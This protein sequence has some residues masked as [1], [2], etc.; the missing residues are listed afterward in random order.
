[1]GR[2]ED[3]D[4]YWG[5]GVVKEAYVEEFLKLGWAGYYIVLV[6]TYLSK[7]YGYNP[8][9]AYDGGL[10]LDK[11]SY[12]L[13]PEVREVCE[14]FNYK[15][16]PRTKYRSF[17]GSCNNLRNPY[18]GAAMTRT[19]RLVVPD[20]HDGV[21]GIRRSRDGTPLPPARYLR[22]HLL[23]DK[24]AQE[25]AVNTLSLYYGQ[26]VVHDASH[27]PF[28]QAH[29]GAFLDCCAGYKGGE[30][31]VSPKCYTVPLPKDDTFYSKQRVD[32]LNQART[33]LAP[34][35]RCAAGYG[36]QV[37]RQSA[38][39][40]LSLA[41]GT[42]KNESD[43][44]RTKEDGLLKMSK[45]GDQYLLPFDKDAEC[46]NTTDPGFCMTS[47]DLRSTIHPGITLLQ[48]LIN[49]NHNYC[50]KKIYKLNPHWNDEK[51]FQE[52]R[53][54][55]IA[56]FQHIT[57]SEYLP[58]ILGWKFMFD[59]GLLPTT[60]G[61]SYDYDETVN[62][63]VYAEFTGAAFRCHSSVYGK[64]FLMD[65]NYNVEKV[66]D[67]HNHY[68]DPTI[69]KT[70]SNFDSL[71]RG[72]LTSP[73]RKL[74]KYYDPSIGELLL[75]DQRHFGLDIA[76]F[77]INRGREYGIRSYNDYR[78]LCGLPR[79]RTWQDFYDWIS[80]ENVA[81]LQKSYR[82]PDDVDVYTAGLLERHQ[83]DS[84]LGPTWWCIAG[85]Q[86]KNWKTG[87]R[88]FYDLGGQPHSFTLPQ[89]D[90]I[91]RMS[92]AAII[93]TL[94]NVKHVPAF[95]FHTISNG[96]PLVACSDIE[97]IPRLQFGPWKENPYY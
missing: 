68:N 38:V 55:N 88:F 51:I 65:E 64:I 78:E 8:A 92:M 31:Q 72:Y 90:Q 94:T 74:D 46:F 60:K 73:Q 48:S 62:P 96:N 15:K 16:C 7:E 93:C 40:D 75:K 34:N 9:S 27:T 61:Y 77:N 35:Y 54:I 53:R 4:S 41:Y 42:T 58:L 2:G 95:A 69:F 36:S 13:P 79:A 30:Q 59:H 19:G 22:S 83:Y 21:W 84:S 11:Y 87:D 28:Y 56:I 71:L 14:T 6:T 18:L 89:L 1:L 26:I 85:Q 67:L 3:D 23:P 81:E 20:Y 43:H 86:F 57:Y 17:D 12:L 37:N 47:G 76:A 82:R 39:L 63:W 24:D 45:V 32:C 91:R 44:L 97:A 33:V 49:R 10:K 50:A 70:P 52:C 80:P 25:K 29:D 5:N 66:E